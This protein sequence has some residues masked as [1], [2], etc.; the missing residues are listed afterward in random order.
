MVFRPVRVAIG[1]VVLF[2][3]VSFLRLAFFEPAITCEVDLTD[4]DFTPLVD[5]GTVPVN[6]DVWFDKEKNQWCMYE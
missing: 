5:E 3:L 2:S 1:V 4:L 6:V